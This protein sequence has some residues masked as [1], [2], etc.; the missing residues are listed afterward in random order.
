[1]FGITEAA[2]CS[3][4]SVNSVKARAVD[5]S[6]LGL[7]CA[8]LYLFG[9][10]IGPTGVG[11]SPA[12]LVA[13]ELAVCTFRLWSFAALRTS[14]S[15]AGP[16]W[17]KLCDRGPYGIIRHPQALAA[18]CG[19]AIFMLA[20][21]SVVNGLSYALFVGAV[22]LTVAIE[23]RFLVRFSAWRKYSRRVAYRF[24]PGMV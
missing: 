8:V 12:W 10:I 1:M 21:P 4:A 19:R 3:V 7:S 18:I 20:F 11:A 16:T 6:S 24:V 15:V 5:Q 22:V 14:Y 13:A 9:S 23:E 2:M 17:L